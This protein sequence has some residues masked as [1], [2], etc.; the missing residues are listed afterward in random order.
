MDISLKN[1]LDLMLDLM[2]TI[3]CEQPAMFDR[4]CAD[5]AKIILYG[6]GNTGRDLA[7]QLS[8]DYGRRLFF[9]DRRQE[10]WGGRIDGIP[11]LNPAEAA[12]LYGKDSVFV[13]TVFNREFSSDYAEIVDYLRELGASCCIPWVVPAWK[14][15]QALLPR[16]FLGS[17]EDILP[18]KEDI[19]RIFNALS[20]DRSQVIFLELMEASLTAPFDKLSKPERG[21]QY[22]IPEALAQLTEKVC[23]VDCG[24][25]DGDTLRDALSV[26]GAGRIGE[27][28]A[29]EPDPENFKRLQV[30]CNS[31]PIDLRNRI[32]CYQAAAG[33]K[34]GS[35]SFVSTGTE[36][37]C[38]AGEGCSNSISCLTLDSIL[39]KRNCNSIFL[40]MDVEGYEK[41]ALLGAVHTLSDKNVKTT[42]A[43]SVY[44][45]QDDF[46]SIPL[47]IK[48]MTGKYGIFRKHMANLF[49]TVYYNF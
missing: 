13:I 45:R 21:P 46:Y 43:I 36:G 49:E 44:H 10:L 42:L 18:F 11:V 48:K 40:K 34:E 15:K 23:I 8:T 7:A 20:E 9:A 29:I 1:R 30:F 14:Y 2:E 33:A 47:L 3:A 5:K 26:L 31:L 12:R 32:S 17:A 37:S 41:D 28:F 16:F 25:Y 35:V 27:Y 24:A 4:I 19:H 39:K 38:V 6:A 22:F